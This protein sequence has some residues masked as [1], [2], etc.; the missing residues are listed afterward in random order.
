LQCCDR[1][2]NNT[3]NKTV[4]TKGVKK[5]LASGKSPIENRKKPKPPSFN[6]TP[7]RITEPDVGASQ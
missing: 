1:P 4:K 2:I 5:A 3:K 7:A 6:R